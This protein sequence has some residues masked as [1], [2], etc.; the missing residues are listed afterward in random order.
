V[1]RQLSR[2]RVLSLLGATAGASALAACAR[3]EPGGQWDLIVVGGGNAGLPAAIFAAERGAK[4]LVVDIAPQIGGSLWLSSGQMSAAGTKLQASKGIEDS[5]QSHYDDVM[6]ISKGTADPDILRLAVFNAAETFDWLTDN[7]F[8]VHDDHPVTGTTHEP[9]SHARYAWGLEGGRSLLALL[10]EQLQPHIDAGQ[11]TV[12]TS[13]EVV[14]L[15]QEA[16]GSIGGIIARD[17]GGNDVRHV[18]KSTLLTCGGYASNAE[19]FERLEGAKDYSDVSY[20][21]SQG[22]GITMAVAAG[23]YVRGGEHH[24]PLFGGIMADDVYPAR[25]IGAVRPWPPERPPWEIYVNVNGERFMREDIASHDIHEHALLEQPEER[26][27]VVFDEAIFSQSP[28]LVRGSFSGPWTPDDVRAAFDD[29]MAMFYKADT[30]EALAE[31]AGIDAAGLTATLAEYNKGQ[32]DGNDRFG[33]EHMPVPIAEPPYYAV[34][35]QSWLLTAFAGVAVDQGLRVIREDGTPIPNLYAAG[36]L[37]GSG[38]F[39]GRSYCGGM[40]VTPALTFGRLLGQKL[41]PLA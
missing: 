38:Q 7:G 36:E 15:V 21:Y 11:V 26:C 28:Q 12:Q 41:L 16:D 35:L 3:K 25:M 19:M 20:P 29:G 17:T 10:E 24:L 34:Q 32:A 22:A 39:M 8:V 23:G 13:T 31:I 1:N 33:R 5:P 4:V 9:Y 30:P 18:A 37:L 6:R 40:L 2:R 14:G 27:W